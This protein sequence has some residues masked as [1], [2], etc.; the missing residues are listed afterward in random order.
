MGRLA[1]V[2][3]VGFAGVLVGLAAGVMIVKHVAKAECAKGVGGGVGDALGKL[4][5]S[6]TVGKL[7]GQLV[8]DLIGGSS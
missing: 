6:T 7:A 5:H 8:T 4:T 3:A 1:F 2:A